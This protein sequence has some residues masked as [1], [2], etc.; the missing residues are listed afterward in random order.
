MKFKA[1]YLCLIFFIFFQNNLYSNEINLKA[2]E[3]LTFEEGNI[4]VGKNEVEAKI[5]GEFEIYADKI[6]YN[7]IKNK[8]VAEGNVSSRDLIN[9]I[10]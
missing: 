2:Q 7:K 1:T 4:I 9:D 8:L 5:N 10:E 3:I 6:T